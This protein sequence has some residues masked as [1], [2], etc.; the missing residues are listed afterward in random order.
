[1]IVLT[2]LGGYLTDSTT[3]IP[4]SFPIGSVDFFIE[5]INIM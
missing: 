2:V 3:E 1:M 4:L 5:Y